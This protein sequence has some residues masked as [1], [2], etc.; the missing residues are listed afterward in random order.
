MILIELITPVHATMINPDPEQA[1]QY[2]RDYATSM[3]HLIQLNRTCR[4][5]KSTIEHSPILRKFLFLQSKDLKEPIFNPCLFYPSCST[6]RLHIIRPK[7]ALAMIIETLQRLGEDTATFYWTYFHRR[8]AILQDNASWRDMNF[9][10]H[11]E[12]ENALVHSTRQAREPVALNDSTY[13]Y[14][15][16][17]PTKNVTPNWIIHCITQLALEEKPKHSERYRH[18]V[19][20][21]QKCHTC[22]VSIPPASTIPKAISILSEFYGSYWHF[23]LQL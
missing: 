22:V 9:V 20:S 13:L 23:W 7:F 12:V 18:F 6:R 3:K 1:R 10:Y 4:F 17:K 2:Y 15:L 14:S 8:E 16:P 21:L 5:W 11:F 19:L